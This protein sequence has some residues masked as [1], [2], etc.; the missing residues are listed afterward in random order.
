V[1]KRRKGQRGTQWYIPK[2]TRKSY[3]LVARRSE[4]PA[5]HKKV[6]PAT[7]LIVVDDQEEANDAIVDINSQVDLP[8]TGNVGSYN[9]ELADESDG[10]ETVV[11]VNRNQSPYLLADD[12][13]DSF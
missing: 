9:N 3:V 10:G 7:K 6:I 4:S 11:D 5:V 12:S 1:S 8:K 2:T 13:S